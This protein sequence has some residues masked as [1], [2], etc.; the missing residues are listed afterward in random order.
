M[1]NERNI[2]IMSYFKHDFDNFNTIFSK[3]QIQKKKISI[4][5]FSLTIDKFLDGFILLSWHNQG[6]LLKSKK[7]CTNI[8]ALCIEYVF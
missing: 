7:I 1:L 5:K 2:P 6:L 3:Y 4:T 8:I